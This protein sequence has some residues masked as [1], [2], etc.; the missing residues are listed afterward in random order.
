MN[1]SEAAKTRGQHPPGPP[2]DRNI[3]EFIEH[4]E[5]IEVRV[6]DKFVLVQDDTNFYVVAEALEDSFENA[7]GMSRIY[8]ADLVIDKA[9]GRVI[10]S[11]HFTPEGLG[12]ADY[13]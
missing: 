13:M 11:R 10:K 2:T 6:K 12:P 5:I 9:S 7:K 8:N 1:F 3:M 4:T